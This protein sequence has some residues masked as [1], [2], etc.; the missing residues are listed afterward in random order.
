[1]IGENK[2]FKYNKVSMNKLENILKKMPEKVLSL[3]GID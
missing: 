1:M 2:Y 3:Y